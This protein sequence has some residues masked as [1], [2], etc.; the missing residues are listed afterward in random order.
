MENLIISEEYQKSGNATFCHLCL[1]SDVH[2][3]GVFI[4]D[5]NIYDFETIKKFAKKDALHR[6][7]RLKSYISCYDTISGVHNS[8]LENLK[9][10]N[11]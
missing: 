11:F 3:I 10:F 8:N 6:V 4:V 7:E 5:D 9:L 2:S 1:K